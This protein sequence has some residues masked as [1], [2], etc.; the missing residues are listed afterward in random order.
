MRKD[1]RTKLPLHRDTLRRLD[2]ENLQSAAMRRAR[3]GLTV[4]VGIVS[5]DDQECTYSRACETLN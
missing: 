4:G 2:S 1:A 5:S 3:G